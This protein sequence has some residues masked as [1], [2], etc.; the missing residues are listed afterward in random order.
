MAS[1][2]DPGEVRE[3]FLCPLC[4]KDLQSFY[5]LQ[6]HYEEEHLEDRDVKGQIKNLVQ[7]ARKAKNKLLKREGDDRVEPGTQG[8]ESF[9]YGG[10][11]PYMWEPQE[12]G[13]MRSHLSDFKKH[14]AA[15]IDH[16][17]V[18]VNKL[19]IRLEKLTAF[20]RTNTETSKI[21][22]IEK[23]VVPWVN[24]QDVPFC[25]DC[26]NKFSIRNRRHHCRL[27]GSIM[28]KKCMELIGLPLAHKLT[29]ASKDS[30]ST[31]TSPS[32]SPNSVHGSR[33]G[34]IS[35][36]SSVSS[37]LDEKD[38]DRIRCCTHCKDKLLKREQQMDE[39]EHTPDI[40]KLYEKLRLCMEKV[41]QK[42]PEYIR[43]AAS[44]N[45]GETTYNL[46]HANDLRV[47]VQKVYELIDALSKK[48]LTLG[49]NQ[50]P[51]PHPNTLRLQ[52]MIRYSA[53]LFVQEKLLG[54]MS[55]PT[56][57]QF[58]ELK[59]KRKQDLEQKRTVERQAALESRR[60]LEE[61]QSGL[62]SHTANGDVRSLRGIPPPLRKAEGW[63][64]L[65]EGQGQSEDPDPL[66]QQ[67]YN[68]TSFIRQAKAAGRTDEVRTLQ[69]NLR[70]LQDEY[71]QQQTE[72]AIELS[73]KQAEEEELQR[74][75]LQMLRKRELER[76]QE[77]FLAASLQTRTRVLE[78][79][80]VIPF[81]L[82]ASRGPHIDLSYSLDQD[83]S[84]VQS[85]TAPDILTPGSA[86]A[87]M[88]LWS[89]PPALGQETLPQSTMSQQ[90]DKA[91]LNPFDE[92]DLSSPTEGAI[93][94]AA[95]EAFLGPPAAVTKEYNPFEE[96]AEE[97]EV[98]ELGAGN[99]FTDPDSPAPNPFDED[100]GPRPASPAAPGNPFEEC[101]STNPFEV[102]SDSG[103][104]AEEHIEEELLLQQIDNIKAYIFDAKQCGRMD[105]V[106]VLTEN[107][108]ELKCTLAKQKGAPN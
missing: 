49:L 74:E 97:E 33:R 84:P 89:G 55:L 52:R 62:A 48:I 47:E 10:V 8:Y 85:S 25:P 46:E 43:M 6:S 56:K 53:T 14:R 60:K 26:G 105:E 40:V 24:D 68:I 91:S 76:E 28:C 3:G 100:D 21:R 77:Q 82:E 1:L 19:I 30:L 69:E 87:P 27:C 37:V 17:V 83:S 42:A 107:L 63:L 102:D 67:I 96:D 32:Q 103:M 51:S 20:D 39:K 88:H 15:R 90:S 86:L 72:K 78:L 57:E 64:P 50:D 98:A 66:L 75:Q 11:D 38:D 73:R 44:L 23:S 45:A 58:E 94:P 81:Q 41:D 13:A 5:Q 35:S 34:S 93:S 31:H 104:E 12:L 29:S 101:P 7:K 70:Q 54:L 2:D 9:S 106:E 61:R 22:A 16:Y 4:L 79:R 99:P 92:D 95:V 108:R 18:E 65:S 59:K 36:M 80:E 71:D